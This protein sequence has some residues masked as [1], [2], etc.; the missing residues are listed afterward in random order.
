MPYQLSGL[1]KALPARPLLHAVSVHDM[2]SAYALY[3]GKWQGY[4]L[5]CS[6]TKLYLLTHMVDP[7]N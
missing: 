1:A 4:N 3:I 7:R 6:Y 2:S 5:Y